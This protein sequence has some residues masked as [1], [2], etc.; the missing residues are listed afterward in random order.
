VFACFCGL[1]VPCGGLVCWL[2]WG[3]NLPPRLALS[4]LCAADSRPGFPALPGSPR[5]PASA[6]GAGEVQI[7]NSFGAQKYKN[8]FLLVPKN[9][10]IF[11]VLLAPKDTRVFWEVSLQRFSTACGAVPVYNPFGVQR[12]KRTVVGL[13]VLSAGAAVSI[14]SL[15]LQ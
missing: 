10:R 15:C 13:Q 8:F 14:A 2:F 6:Y 11:L 9:T 12:Y 1:C 3:W 7:F 4:A 5:C